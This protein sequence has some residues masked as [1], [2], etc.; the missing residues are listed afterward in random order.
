[1]KPRVTT[2]AKEVGQ[3]IEHSLNKDITEKEDNKRFDSPDYDQLYFSDTDLYMHNVIKHKTLKAPTHRG[4]GF[5][6]KEPNNKPSD[7]QADL[8]SASNI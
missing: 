8:F 4:G 2:A 5:K 7:T 3:M 1:M 6:I